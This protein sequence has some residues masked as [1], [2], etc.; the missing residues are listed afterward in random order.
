MKASLMIAAALLCLPLVARADDEPQ[1]KKS[2][3]YHSNRQEKRI[4]SGEKSGR[5]NADE[6]AKIDAKEK[7]IDEERAQAA[8]DGKITKR[9]R[10]GIRHEQKEA[11]QDIHQMK[12]N[13]KKAPKNS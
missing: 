13:K 4:K 12:H 6:A 5:L 8:A 11:S 10:R 9:E 3:Q 1:Q 2:I 7:A